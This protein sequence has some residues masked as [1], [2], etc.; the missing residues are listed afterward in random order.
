MK[1][2]RKRGFTLVELLVVIAIIGI[3]VALL[4]PAI[5]AAREA[6]RRTQCQNNVKQLG[7]ALFNYHDSYK[8]FPP[9]G[10]DYGWSGSGG[11][12]PAT[13]LVKNIN[14][15]ALLLPYIEQQALHSQLNFGQAFS[16]VGP[17]PQTQSNIK[18][19]VRP[20][21]GNAGTSGN[22]AALGEI[23]PGFV[24]PSDRRDQLYLPTTGVYAI[25]NGSGV[26]AVK[27]NYDFSVAT[28]DYST[29]NDWLTY[30]PLT[31][32]MFGENSDSNTAS[33]I[34][35]TS[36][37]IA[38]GETCHWVANGSCP[39][40]GF[41]GWVM[42]GVDVGANG[43]NQFDIPATYTWVADKTTILGRLRTWASVGSAHPGGA[44]ILMGDASARFVSE[45]TDR[46][47]LVAIATMSGGEAVQVP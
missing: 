11:A 14:G 25:L 41:R 43:I 12:E 3:L 39:A 7:V 35:G 17:A 2:L 1:W 6:A 24:C 28:G 34:D 15:L 31:K 33:V 4:L 26:A 13:K 32:R 46:T 44:N 42:S 29:F 27:T 20:I 40:W 36:N 21:A 23:V 10:L 9:A 37:T 8:V 18:A 19:S 45:N 47:V 5:Q 22:A 38:M 16:H 30:N